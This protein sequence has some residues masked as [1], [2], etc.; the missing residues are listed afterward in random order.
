MSL[1]DLFGKDA[2][3]EVHRHQVAAS[4]APFKK[5]EKVWSEVQ[6]HSYRLAYLPRSASHLLSH[7]FPN[8]HQ[9]GTTPLII[10][11]QMCHTDLCRLLLQQGAAANDQDLQGRYVSPLP[12]SLLYSV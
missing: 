12:V 2:V 5:C 8:F 3:F 4:Q 7:P 10:A 11:A 9:S 6:G 1:W